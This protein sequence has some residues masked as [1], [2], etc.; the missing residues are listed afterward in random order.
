[1]ADIFDIHMEVAQKIVDAMKVSMSESE[2]QI[3]TQKP[4]KDFRA[5]DFYMRGRDILSRRGKQN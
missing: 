2:K 1:M 4:T 5:D 3:L